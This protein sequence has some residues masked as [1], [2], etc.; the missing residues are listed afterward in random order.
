VKKKVKLPLIPTQPRQC[1]PIALAV[2]RRVA[3][4]KFGLAYEIL[5]AM[6]PMTGN[7]AKHA[8]DSWSQ[9]H[10]VAPALLA[11]AKN[12]LHSVF[13]PMELRFGVVK[14]VA[15]RRCTITGKPCAVWD[16][17]DFVPAGN[18]SWRQADPK[19]AKSGKRRRAA[20]KKPSVLD[21]MHPDLLLHRLC[22]IRDNL[23]ILAGAQLGTMHA[24]CRELVALQIAEAQ[25]RSDQLRHEHTAA[26]QPILLQNS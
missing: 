9:Q 21:A 14:K 17:T 24:A 11:S 22:A 1:N 4:P 16:V 5:Y 18:I 20:T 15:Q 6:G 8:L 25:E 13:S 26:P 23:A 7:E 10:N 2:I 3:G 12:N 19:R